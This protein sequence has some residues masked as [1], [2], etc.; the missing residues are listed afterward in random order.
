MTMCRQATHVL[1]G[2]LYS[3]ICDID[4]LTE[5]LGKDDVTL[6]FHYFRNGVNLCSLLPVSKPS[7]VT[8]EQKYI[9][10]IDT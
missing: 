10:A 9:I 8:I 7:I 2:A 5:F 6:L 1:R 3:S 4:G